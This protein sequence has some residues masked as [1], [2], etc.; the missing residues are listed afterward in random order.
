[1]DK[2]EGYSFDKEQFRKEVMKLLRGNSYYVL[3]NE[4]IEL[5]KK[6]TNKL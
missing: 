3:T 1:M 2:N 5:I 6:I 4:E